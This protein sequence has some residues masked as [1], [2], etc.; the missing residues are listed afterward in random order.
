MWRGLWRRLLGPTLPVP[1]V[2]AIICG[3][4]AGAVMAFVL[5]SRDHVL[6]A[7]LLALDLLLF[8]MAMLVATWLARRTYRPLFQAAEVLRRVG[9]DRFVHDQAPQIHDRDLQPAI[10]QIW[11][12][13]RTL[14]EQERRL[15]RELQH[16][17][18]KHAEAR[19][20]I[21]L[22]AE[23]NK[24]LGL[25]AILERLA[26][27]LSKF[28]AGDAVAIWIRSSIDGGLELAVSAGEQFP[29]QLDGREQWVATV[30]GGRLERPHLPSLRPEQPSLAAPVL[31]ARG[32]VIGIVALVSSKRLGYSPEEASFLQMVI[33]YAALP[34]QNAVAFDQTDALS[35]LDGLTG[36]YNRR[37]FDR[38][39][40]QEWERARRYHN[41]LSLL[42]IDIDH[43]KQVNDE[44]GHAAG[45]LALQQVARIIRVARIRGSDAAFRVGGE[46]FGILLPETDKP[47]AMALAERVRQATESMR[48]FSDGSGVTI[49]IG[50]A[51]FPADGERIE[52]LHEAAD[53]A[54][55][56]AKR[57]GRNRVLAAS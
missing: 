46:E 21:D 43:F 9:R 12:V 55:Y 20:L 50:V 31:D 49:S 40:R 16:W 19:N 36:L 28:F 17:Q 34:I 29:V 48:F 5:I 37:E 33:G 44:R 15:A 30:L 7:S 14:T 51:T 35:R 24:A 26:F 38:V 3:T 45:D 53:A 4:G 39:L 25:K 6:A 47:G 10:D 23:M 57:A 8:V 56:A 42:I 22:I 27:G 18:R 52:D 1:L 11:Q 32:N 13:G 2:F 54:L 41:Q